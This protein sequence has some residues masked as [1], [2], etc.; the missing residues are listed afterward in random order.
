[1]KS[2]DVSPRVL[3]LLL[4]A[5]LVGAVVF[6]NSHGGITPSLAAILGS[7]AGSIPKML[8][9]PSVF[10]G[11]GDAQPS[12]PP[13]PGSTIAADLAAPTVGAVAAMAIAL[14]LGG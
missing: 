13:K 4:S 12:P 10:G 7:I 6:A 14:T 5:L 3:V 9:R 8:E 11:P 2:L 1:M